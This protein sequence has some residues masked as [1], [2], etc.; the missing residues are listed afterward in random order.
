MSQTNLNDQYV[1]SKNPN[2]A[3]L[4]HRGSLTAGGFCRC[5]VTEPYMEVF[6][7]TDFTPEAAGNMNHCKW[8]VTDDLMAGSGVNN[9]GVF[10][11]SK[12][13][14]ATAWKVALLLDL[15]AVRCLLTQKGET[16]CG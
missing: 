2:W 3:P 14:L 5:S 1:N 8:R 16:A 13:S 6:S 12:I 9:L 15:L 11:L 7:S 10:I 4:R